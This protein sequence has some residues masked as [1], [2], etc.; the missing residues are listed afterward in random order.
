MQDKVTKSSA[1][2][3]TALT[4]IQRVENVLEDFG[5]NVFLHLGIPLIQF[6]LFCPNF[7]P[8]DFVL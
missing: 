4:E 5:Q 7:W 6:L 2:N 3:A 1:E 8:P